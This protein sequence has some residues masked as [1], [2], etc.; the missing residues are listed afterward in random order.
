MLRVVAAKH[1]IENHHGSTVPGDQGGVPKKEDGQSNEKKGEDRVF[2]TD[3]DCHICGTV[4]NFGSRARCRECSAKASPNARQPKGRGKGSVSKPAY[5]EVPRTNGFWKSK[6]AKLEEAHQ[7]QLAELQKKLDGGAKEE[8]GGSEEKEPNESEAVDLPKEIELARKKRAAMRGLW[9][10]SE[11]EVLAIEE[12]IKELVRQR[13]E[14]KPPRV[15]LQR[16]EWRIQSTQKQVE[17]K[18]KELQEIDDRILALLEDRKEKKAAV[19]S[20]KRDLEVAKADRT[21]EL[22]RALKEE[23][24]GDNKG[25]GPE[26]NRAIGASEAMEVLRRETIARLPADR[27]QVGK[28]IDQAF[29]QLLSLLAGL[30]GNSSSTGAGEAACARK[31]EEFPSK[32]LESGVAAPQGEVPASGTPPHEPK[33]VAQHDIGDDEDFDVDLSGTEDYD[34]EPLLDGMETEKKEGESDHARAERIAAWLAEKKEKRGKKKA[35]IKGKSNRGC[36]KGV[37]T[38]ATAVKTAGKS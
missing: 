35:R 12:R 17:S 5:S 28:D 18:A 11:P 31:S 1:R 38:D 32:I 36:G 14:E 13:D 21:E 24:M 6:L 19:A 4:R 7:K 37:A 30:P 22:Q 2:Y 3:W 8:A 33:P 29:T 10:D 15:R 26:K 27:P 23:A 20:A 25:E 34:D 16:L 9:K